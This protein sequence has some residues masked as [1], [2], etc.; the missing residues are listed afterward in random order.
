MLTVV[1]GTGCA[2]YQ[3]NRALL[4]LAEDERDKFPKGAQVLEENVYVD[5]AFA[6]ATTYK[7]PCM[8]ET[9]SSR[10]FSQQ[11]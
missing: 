2:P 3:A 5:D 9:N 11:A 1:Y 7:K 8:S 4:K 6:E 10:F